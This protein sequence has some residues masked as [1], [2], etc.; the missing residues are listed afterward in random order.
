MSKPDQTSHDDARAAHLET[1]VSLQTIGEKL[2]DARAAL[3]AGV[4]AIGAA[5]AELEA[6]HGYL[7]AAR[8]AH[9]ELDRHPME[10][11]T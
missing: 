3:A 11:E 4:R 2:K 9:R 7:A 5:A 1:A 8:D 10:T 6:A